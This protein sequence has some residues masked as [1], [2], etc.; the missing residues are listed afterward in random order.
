VV[1]LPGDTVRYQNKVTYING[2]RVPQSFVDEETVGG[3][4]YYRVYDET[5]GETT[6]RIFN[7][8]ARLEPPREWVVPEGHYFVMGDNRGRSDDSRRWGFVPDHN[9]VG[10][11]VAI[12]IHKDPGLHWPTFNR[13][14][15]I[16]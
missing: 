5:L 4:V 12:W 14:G 6:H 9:V 7:Y 13:N 16:N 2:E 8:P 15:L 11:A 1:G 3:Q 10:K